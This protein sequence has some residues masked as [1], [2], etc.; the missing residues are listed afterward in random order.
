MARGG[1]A[2]MATRLA[3]GAG[4]AA[5]AGCIWWLVEVAA[6]WALGGVLTRASAL[7][8]LSLDVAA[9]AAGGAI[10]ALVSGASSA[11][12]L[13]LGMT[14]VYGFLRVFEPP[15]VMGEAAYLVA[16]ALTAF[17][18]ARLVRSRLGILAFV[19]LTLVTTAATVL[20]K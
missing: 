19:H 16:G 11:P 8:I 7:H 1:I 3:R 6:N 13:A 10:V 15:G 4:A 14:V 17:L 12:A 20:G 2:G 5:A 18:A 9:A